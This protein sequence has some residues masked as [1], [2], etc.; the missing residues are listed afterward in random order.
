MGPVPL[1]LSSPLR[2]I[3]K[4]IRRLA[5]TQKPPLWLA[6]VQLQATWP[7]V[8]LHAVHTSPTTHQARRLAD[9][10]LPQASGSEPQ[11][12]AS[13]RLSVL[14]ATL[15]NT[16]LSGGPP[17]PWREVAKLPAAPWQKLALRQDLAGLALRQGVQLVAP[18]PGAPGQFWVGSNGQ[19]DLYGDDQKIASYRYQ[20]FRKPA[21]LGVCALAEQPTSA[22]VAQYALN[23]DRQLPMFLRQVDATGHDTVVRSWPAGEV[24]H[25]HFVQRDPYS[26]D[27]WVGSGDR[28]AESAIWRSGDNGQTWQTVGSGS[29]WWRTIGVAFLP[30]CVVWGTDAGIDAE[31]FD[32][33][34]VR[35]DRASGQMTPQQAVEGPVHGIAVR[36]DGA[37][38]ITT[39]CEGGANER[40]GRVHFWQG[41]QAGT[42]WHHLGDWPAGAQPRRVQY[43]VAHPATGIHPPGQWLVTLRG[44]AGAPLT[45]IVLHSPLGR[46]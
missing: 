24:R 26:G 39:G 29:Q 40:D 17:P 33:A 8:V 28:D 45:G 16:N 23:R 21:R 36:A 31:Q 22:L 37:V 35:W 38:L 9:S 5:G 13:Q 19:L 20:G 2:R 25:L 32:N 11:V 15:T 10:N 27:W 43:A 30:D 1:R 14:W 7:G 12:W 46:T 41:E 34:I 44:L 3:A 6:T 18:V 4:T 42:R